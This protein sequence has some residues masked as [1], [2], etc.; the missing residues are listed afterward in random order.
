MLAFE[1]KTKPFPHQDAE[2]ELSGA[3]KSRALWWEPGCGKTKPTIDTAAK[4]YLGGEIQ[5]LLVLAPNGVQRN[6]LTDEVP[7]H[8]P[9]AVAEQ[10]QCFLWNTDKAKQVGF[11]AA[12]TEFM[13]KTGGL[14]ILAMSFDSLMTD[15]G[16]KFARKFLEKR[17][18]MEVLDES[19]R[20][21]SPGAKRTIRVLASGAYSPYRRC[22]TGTPSSNSPFDAYTQCKF[23]DPE[24][25]HQFGISNFGSF[26]SFFGVWEKKFSGGPGGHE[27][28]K[29]VTYRNLP[30]LNKVMTSVGSRLLKKD[31]LDLPPKLYTKVYYDLTPEQRRA[32]A[33]LQVEYMTWLSDGSTVTADLALTRMI[34][35]QQITSGYLPA[36]DERN[37]RPLGSTNPR[38][39]LLRD[40][41]EDVPGQAL[42]WGKYDIDIDCI[43]AMLKK[44]EKT[45][46]LYDG[47]TSDDDRHEAKAAYQRGD[48]QFFVGK[49]SC[50]GTGLTLH[51]GGTVIF[52]NNSYKLDDR[53]QAEDRAHRIGQVNDKVLYIDLVANDTIDEGIVNALRTKK[54]ISACVTGDEVEEW[55]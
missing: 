8:M 7:A 38:L 24:I 18:S 1:Y 34:R 12:A 39:E 4:L 52:Y 17:R 55:I 13:K 40:T 33:Q 15:V 30:I 51:A 45:F 23:L 37:L 36:D 46:C 10:M 25:W 42:I 31:V 47:R 41:L 27:Y 22:L 35:F 2:L 11:Q 21:K 29:L 28:P 26:K 50:A 19:H 43:A 53:I 14:S 5:G 16:A 54:E 3:L 20:I 32:Y 44:E 9:T 49:A 6:W 48:V